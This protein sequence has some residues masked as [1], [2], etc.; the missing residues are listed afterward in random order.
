MKKQGRVLV[1][2]SENTFE[3]LRIIEENGRYCLEKELKQGTVVEVCMHGK[4]IPF[5]QAD[6]QSLASEQET[7]GK[8]YGQG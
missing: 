6:L 7:L 1:A 2:R 5:Q 3:L 8:A 4:Y